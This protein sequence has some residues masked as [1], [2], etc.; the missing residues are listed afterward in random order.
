MKRNQDIMKL[1]SVKMQ[2]EQLDALLTT[3]TNDLQEPNVKFHYPPQ[4]HDD[5]EGAEVQK[6]SHK[7][8]T[9]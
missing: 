7:R 4:E 9:I 6:E 5:E 1:L 2:T 3:I 8:M